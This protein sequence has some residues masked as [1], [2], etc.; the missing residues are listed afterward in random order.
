MII[1]STLNKD[2]DFIFLINQPNHLD[3]KF[4]ICLQNTQSYLFI[5]RN[6]LKAIA[7]MMEISWKIL[8]IL[9][10]LA[11]VNLHAGSMIRFLVATTFST[12]VL[13]KIANFFHQLVDHVT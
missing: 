3:L 6:L 7:S 9:Q 1:E 11:H 10:V 2:F 12:M 8:V 13:K 4:E 5:L